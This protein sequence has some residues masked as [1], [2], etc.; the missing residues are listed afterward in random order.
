[1]SSP[2]WIALSM[3]AIS[4]TLVEGTWLK[5]LRA[6][7]AGAPPDLAQYAAFPAGQSAPNPAAARLRHIAGTAWSTKRYLNIELL[8]DQQMRGAITR[9]SQ[10]GQP[11]NR[12][13]NGRLIPLNVNREVAL[14]ICWRIAYDLTVYGTT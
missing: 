5:I 1:M 4:R 7:D 8:K 2:A 13:L 9:P 14:L 6:H 3:A 12:L 10:L 11:T